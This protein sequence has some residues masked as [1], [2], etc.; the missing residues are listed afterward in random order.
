M[1]VIALNH[2][3]V[4]DGGTRWCWVYG[5]WS[6]EE[7]ASEFLARRALQMRR[8][9][10]SQVDAYDGYEAALVGAEVNYGLSPPFDYWI[11]DEAWVF[12]P[13]LSGQQLGE[14]P[15]LKLPEGAKLLHITEAH[16][17]LMA[18]AFFAEHGHYPDS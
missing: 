9:V 17:E 1:D 15:E 13:C 4:E 10:F 18:E 2:Y 7:Y 3:D 8:L 5:P 11:I 6:S 16:F 12:E 14:L